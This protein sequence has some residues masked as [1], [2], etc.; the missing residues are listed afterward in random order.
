M[1]DHWRRG[2]RSKKAKQLGIVPRTYKPPRRTGIN[3]D[4]LSYEEYQAAQNQ[5]RDDRAK[6]RKL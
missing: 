2:Q 1:S 5:I 3:P 6:G 4:H